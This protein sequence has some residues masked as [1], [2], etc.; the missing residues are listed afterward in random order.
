MAEDSDKDTTFSMAT[1]SKSLSSDSVS[2]VD[3]KAEVVRKKEEALYNKF[4]GRTKAN[5]HNN[6]SQKKNNIWSKSNVGVL[7]RNSED[8]EKERKERIRIQMALEQKAEVYDKLKDGRYKD[9]DKLFLVN[10]DEDASYE[11]P[12]DDDEDDWV[13]YTDGLG[14]SR[15][16][17]KSDLP[18]MKKRDMDAFGEEGTTITESEQTMLS[19]DMRRDLLRQKWEREEEENLAKPQLHYTDVLF[20]EAR[21]HGAGHYNFSRNESKRFSEME[22]LKSTHNE[23]LEERFKRDAKKSHD[24]AKLKARLKKVRD[25]KRLKMGLPALPDDDDDPIVYNNDKK[26]NEPKDISIED[27]VTD[28]LRSL[29]QKEEIDKMRNTIV[30]E[31]DV[32]K[33]GV[34]AKT[35]TDQDEFKEKLKITM[36]RKVLDQQEWVDQKRSERANE[37]APPTGYDN[38]GG[39]KKSLDKSYGKKSYSN[40]PPPQSQAAPSIPKQSYQNMPPP[41]SRSGQSDFYPKNHPRPPN[42]SSF[43]DSHQ[44]FPP[45]SFPGYSNQNT[46]GSSYG[47]NTNVPPP[48]HKPHSN[49]VQTDSFGFNINEP[50]PEKKSEHYHGKCYL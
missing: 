49:Q 35:A 1:A 48:G 27:S 36:E 13:E 6:D 50:P 47:V 12:D 9:K 17:H 7:K 18:D 20:D 32:G 10:F 33:E 31:W 21:T 11:I 3:L 42:Q 16:C 46:T 15:K 43:G 5:V 45:N 25:K 30:R 22:N 29:R 40:V 39:H 44:I 28:T 26:I 34:S 41:P 8:A 14:R 4:H 23:T 2:M 37:F 19:E 24:D 38:K